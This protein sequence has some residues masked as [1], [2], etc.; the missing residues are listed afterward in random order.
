MVRWILF[1]VLFAAGC[2]AFCAQRRESQIREQIEAKL[3]TIQPLPPPR[4]Q[5]YGQSSAAPGVAAERVSYATG[6]GLRVPA[7]LYHEAGATI[8]RHPALI[9]ING[10]ADK[11]TWYDY[12]AGIVYAR[13]GALVLTYDPPGEYERDESRASSNKAEFSIPPGELGRRLGETMVTDAMAAVNYL[14]QRTDVDPKRIAVL[15]VPASSFI[16][17]LACAVDKQIHSCVLGKGGQ[18]AG[19]G[20]GFF[21]GLCK[22]VL[23][24]LAGSKHVLEYPVSANGDAYFLARPAALWLQRELKFRNWTR[25]QIEAMPETRTADGTMAL[26]SNI[27]AVPRDELFAVPLVVW[28]SRKDSYTYESWLVRAKAA[29]AREA[30]QSGGLQHNSGRR[31]DRP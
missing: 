20:A 17:A 16:G 9:V 12:W 26:G 19:P 7:I 29:I 1:S 22:Q 15:T 5:S 18:I 6:Y 13:A 3:H 21:S 27:P 30:T 23:E 4:A 11:S 28:E 8:L 14:A 31:R 24:E 2:T 10:P 25:K